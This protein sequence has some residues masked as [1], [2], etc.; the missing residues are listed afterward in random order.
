MTVLSTVHHIIVTNGE[1]VDIRI[2]H[3]RRRKTAGRRIA[4]RCSCE[5]WTLFPVICPLKYSLANTPNHASPRSRSHQRVHASRPA[6]GSARR[7]SQAA[8]S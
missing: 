7:S 2:W 8:L 3:V 6:Q 4:G 1:S 5:D